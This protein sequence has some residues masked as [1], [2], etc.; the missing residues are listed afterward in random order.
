MVHLYSVF[1]LNVAF[2]SIEVTQYPAVIE[3]C[4]WPLLKLIDKGILPAGIELTGY[5]LETIQRLDPLWVKKFKELLH[6]KKC[7]LIGSGYTQIIG[8]LVPAKVNGYNQKLGKEVYKSLLNVD[9]TVALINE[10][11]YSQ[12]MLKHYSQCGYSSII[13]EWNNPYHFNNEWSNLLRNRPQKVSDGK[14]QVLSLLWAETIAFQ[15]FQRYAHKEITIEKYMDFI[16][17][18]EIG[19]EVYVP[20]YSNDVEIFD[21]RPGRF[22]TEA[23]LLSP[24]EEWGRIRTLYETLSCDATKKMILPSDALKGLRSSDRECL[25]LETATQ[26]IPV[27]KQEKYNV[28]RWALT[29]RSDLEINSRCYR[30]YQQNIESNDILFWRELCYLWSSDFRTHITRKRWE[31]YVEK[32]GQLEADLVISRQTLDSKTNEQTISILPNADK[33]KSVYSKNDHLIIQNKVYTIGLDLKR[34]LAVS[35]YIVKGSDMPLFG[36]VEHGYYNDISLAADFYS[37]HT[38]IERPGK[39]K[40]TDLQ[41]CEP[42]VSFN[43]ETVF[44]SYGFESTYL[45]QQKSISVS[46]SSLTIY[47]KLSL[48][49]RE[50]ASIIPYSF[51]FNE[52]AWDLETLYFETHNGGDDLEHFS[53]A[54]QELID[55]GR[56]V[57]HLISSKSGIG[58]TEGIVIIGDQYKK[59]CFE[60]DVT[61][62]ALIPT[63]VF[64][65]T[66]EKKIFFR[67]QYSAQEMDD[68][69]KS[70]NN[71]VIIESHIN[72]K[73]W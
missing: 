62:S 10:M 32:L 31:E 1:H 37:G 4:Y 50:L 42:D 33:S 2:S 9:P 45:N 22:E 13:M 3:R 48:P 67:L 66:K 72:I 5:T 34:G 19:E 63:I 6:N 15:K 21:F 55:H 43:G 27:K 49:R 40:I 17:G 47:K 12:G 69:F 57:S 73:Q 14:G 11:A 30:V 58:A 46:D 16:D 71:S 24:G 41:K 70:H 39:H 26:P 56:S 8:P 54:N 18:H 44:V 7:E 29:G 60:H 20:L 23:A 65:V 28:N 53:L 51:T 52:S 38:I 36:V 61:L 35:E 25:H 68:T 59:V 64:K